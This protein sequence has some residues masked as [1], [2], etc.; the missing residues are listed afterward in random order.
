MTLSRWLNVPRR[1][2]WPLR[3]TGL[4]SSSSEPN[5]NASANAQS[6]GPPAWNT[7]RRRSSRLRLSLGS[8]WMFSGTWLTAR[9]M[10]SI[11]ST[12]IAV[13]TVSCEYGG[14]KMAVDPANCFFVS[15]TAWPLAAGSPGA[16][17]PFLTSAK[18]VS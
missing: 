17:A 6:Y 12:G 16:A 2:S 18:A 9:A 13:R 15:G 5:A 4:L 1:L 14:W 11:V 8:T 10:R 3:R 7:L